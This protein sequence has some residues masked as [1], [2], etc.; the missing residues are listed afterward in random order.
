[1]AVSVDFVQSSQDSFEVHGTVVGMLFQLLSVYGDL[2][3]NKHYLKC[4]CI[5]FAVCY[6]EKLEKGSMK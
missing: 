6:L 4:I 2:V 3:L 1:M 5:Y